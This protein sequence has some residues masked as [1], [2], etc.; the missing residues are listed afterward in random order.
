MWLPCW[1]YCTGDTILNVKDNLLFLWEGLDAE[2]F[3]W[4]TLTSMSTQNLLLVMCICAY[5]IHDD[6]ML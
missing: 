6:I 2:N 1:G 3:G 5:N 4:D